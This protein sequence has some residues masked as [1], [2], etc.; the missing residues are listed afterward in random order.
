MFGINK[1]VLRT[2]AA[3][4]SQYWFAV[5]DRCGER[6]EP[7]IQGMPRADE[8]STGRQGFN[9]Y[10]NGGVCTAEWAAG[11]GAVLPA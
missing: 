10:T 8:V 2:G 6:V 3:F 11:G 7:E 9:S 5:D 4:D 1:E